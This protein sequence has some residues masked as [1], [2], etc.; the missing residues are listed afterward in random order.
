MKFLM[1]SDLNTFG[2]QKELTLSISNHL[3]DGYTQDY[4]ICNEQVI[5]VLWQVCHDV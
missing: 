1:V 5:S 3:M 4:L 2:L